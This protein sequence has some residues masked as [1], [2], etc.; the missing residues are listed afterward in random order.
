MA[1]SGKQDE[2]ALR[3]RRD[4]QWMRMLM[5]STGSPMDDRERLKRKLIAY[6]PEMA[7]GTVG[8]FFDRPQYQPGNR[9]IDYWNKLTLTA[10]WILI[11]TTSDGPGTGVA[12]AWVEQ[13]GLPREDLYQFFKIYLR[14]LRAYLRA[15]TRI[16][17]KYADEA[18]Q[19]F[20]TLDDITELHRTPLPTDLVTD[21][22]I[23]RAISYLE[24][25]NNRTHIEGVRKWAGP[26]GDFIY[27]PFE[28]Q[29]WVFFGMRHDW[30]AAL[31]GGIDV[32]PDLYLGGGPLAPTPIEEGFDFYGE[33]NGGET[34]GRQEESTQEEES[35]QLPR[36]IREAGARI[37][38]N[39]GGI[40]PVEYI[41][42]RLLYKEPV[43][44]LGHRLVF[45]A[46]EQIVSREAPKDEGA[47]EESKVEAPTNFLT[48]MRQDK[49]FGSPI[50]QTLAKQDPEKSNGAGGESD[51]SDESPKNLYRERQEKLFSGD[52]SNLCEDEDDDDYAPS[53]RRRFSQGKRGTSQRSGDS[54]RGARRGRY[55][56]SD[57]QTE[58]VSR[59]SRQVLRVTMPRTLKRDI[60]L[61]TP[62][63][64]MSVLKVSK[65]R[66]AK[67]NLSKS[68]LN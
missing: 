22:D 55:R 53:K 59:E 62:S 45:R 42:P 33:A 56:R 52:F 38:P 51:E 2:R 18:L 26:R 17:E 6:F 37:K 16:Y 47:R 27:L 44:E 57:V 29:I 50:G 23:N 54:S 49:L 4:R 36:R 67:P 58:P 34:F 25:I 43:D 41:D 32:H 12:I 60:F 48:A 30:E 46:E 14:Y 5:A 3:R 35:S 24:K 20:T 63:V 39:E 65:L 21:E 8:S 1:S 9:P 61:V 10:Q 11:K 28:E 15:K 13:L 31:T 7:T 40:R 66:A 64:A 68:K 19:L